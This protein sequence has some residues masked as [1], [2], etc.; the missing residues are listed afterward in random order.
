M[1]KS[2]TLNG[3][4]NVYNHRY[5]GVFDSTGIDINYTSFDASFN[6]Q[7]SFKK[8]WAGELSGFYYGRDYFS[9]VMQA[10]GRGMFSLGAS[11]QLMDGKASVKLNLR[12]PF[13]L[14]SFTAHTNLNKALTYSHSVWDNRRIVLTLVY[15]FG[16]AAG[17]S[18]QRRRNGANDEQNRVGGSGQQ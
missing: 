8:G 14:M 12:D 13:Y 9:G 6:T 11:K 16:S 18:Q 15:R 17:N 1:T 2:W 7:Y 3:S 4:F 5:R 10:D